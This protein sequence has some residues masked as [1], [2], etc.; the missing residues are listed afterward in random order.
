MAAGVGAGA[1]EAAALDDAAS[2]TGCFWRQGPMRGAVQSQLL[3]SL[4]LICEHYACACFSLRATRSFDAERLTVMACIAAVADAVL[5]VQVTDTPSLFCVHYSGR[6]GG[7][8][9]PFGFELGRYAIES[10]NLELPSPRLTLSRAKVLRYFLALKKVVPDGNVILRMEDRMRMCTGDAAL[11]GQLC[12]ASGFPRGPSTEALAGYMTGEYSALCRNFP[13]LPLCRDIVFFLKLLMVPTSEGL[14][15]LRAWVPS[16]ATLMWA[17]AK[18]K[19]GAAAAGPPT[20]EVKGFHRQLDCAELVRSARESEDRSAAGGGGGGGGAG[21]FGRVAQFFGIAKPRAPPSGAD[22]STLVGA[23]ISSEDDVLGVRVLPDFGGRLR[24]R[25]VELL[26]CYLTAPYLRI[27]LLL[28]FFSVAERVTALVTDELQAALDGALFEPGLWQ[29]A[30]NRPIPQLVPPPVVAPAVGAGGTSASGQRSAGAAAVAAS[31]AHLATPAGLL[32]NELIHCP[33]ATLGPLIALVQLVLEL[34]TGHHTAS[35]VPAALYL[36]RLAVRV[37]AYATVLL[38]TCAKGSAEAASAF[39]HAPTPPALQQLRAKTELLRVTLRASVAP[40]LGG[41]LARAFKDADQKTCCILHAHIAVIYGGSA[42]LDAPAANALV[43][44]QVFILSNHEIGLDVQSAPEGMDRS[45]RTARRHAVDGADGAENAD[46]SGAGSVGSSKD[47]GL[48]VPVTELMNLFQAK[49]VAVLKWL[50]AHP[51][52]C[53]QIMEGTVG[54]VGRANTAAA[55]ALSIKLE[56]RSWATLRGWGGAG[57]YVPEVESALLDTP[58]ALPG[59]NY[60]AWL[61]RASERNV[62]TEINVQLGQ[63]T[64]QRHH[65]SPLPAY[66]RG[67]PHLHDAMGSLPTDEVIQCIEVATSARSRLVRLPGLRHDVKYFAPALAPPANPFAGGH[68]RLYPRALKASEAWVHAAFERAREAVAPPNAPVWLPATELTSAPFVVLTIELPVGDDARAGSGGVRTALREVV[69]IRSTRVVNAFDVVSHGRRWY[70]QLVWSSSVQWCLADLGPAAPRRAPPP[71][72]PAASLVIVRELSEATGAQEYV[73]PELLKGVLPDALLSRYTFWRSVVGGDLLGYP[74]RARKG[75]PRIGMDGTPKRAGGQES[76]SKPN[77]EDTATANA[78]IAAAA[79]AAMAE[80]EAEADDDPHVLRISLA[81]EP[82]TGGGVSAAGAGATSRANAAA[83][84]V[85]AAMGEGAMALVQRVPVKGGTEVLRAEPDPSR[86]TLTLL[87][88]LT[89]PS[90]TPA[91]ALALA[92]APLEALSH[93]LMWT[94]APV[95]SSADRCRAEM[96]ELPRLRLRFRAKA[97]SGNDEGAPQRVRL[98]SDE[99]TGM[100]ISS[101]AASSQ[102][103]CPRTAALLAGLPHVLLEHA[104]GRLAA[105]VSGAMVPV[106]RAPTAPAHV[107]LCAFVPGGSAWVANL[108]PTSSS[109]L[110]AVHPSKTMLSSPSAAAGL[111]LLSIRLLRGEYTRAV[112]VVRE[113]GDDS[114]F[115]P[116]ARQLF[117]RLGGLLRPTALCAPDLRAVR[118]RLGMWLD[119][120]A[121]GVRF[122]WPSAADLEPYVIQH[123]VVSAA[124]R[125]SPHEEQ[126]LLEA[127][128]AERDGAKPAEMENRLA[129]LRALTAGATAAHASKSFSIRVRPPPMPEHGAT[130]ASAFDLL[131][132]RTCMLT[133]KGSWA[134]SWGTLSY[135][136]PEGEFIEGTPALIAMKGWLRNG[137][138]IGGGRDGLGFLFLYELMTGSLN[139]RVLPTDT[140][141]QWGA[142]LL[143][144]LPAETTQKDGML[145]SILRVLA[146]NP[147]LAAAMP[148]FE[149]TRKFKISTIFRGQDI[150]KDLLQ[151]V[152]EFLGS[153]Q[154]QLHWPSV[155]ALYRSADSVRVSSATL[156]VVDRLAGARTTATVGGAAAAVAIMDEPLSL[157]PAERLWLAP[158]SF[159]AEREA[160]GAMPLI[161]F[162]AVLAGANANPLLQVSDADAKAFASLPL[163]PVGLASY[164]GRRPARLAGSTPSRLPFDLSGVP[165]ARTNVGRATLKRLGDDLADYARTRDAGGGLEMLH[166]LEDQLAA[167][168][169]AADSTPLQRAL[170]HIEGLRKALRALAEKDRRFVEAA[171]LALPSLAGALPSSFVSGDG[172]DAEAHALLRTAGAEPD[173]SFGALLK[174]TLSARGA[175]LLLDLNPFLSRPAADDVLQLTLCTAAATVRVTQAGRADALARELLGMLRGLEIAK[176]GS[177]NADAV[178]SAVHATALKARALASV[179]GEKRHYAAPPAGAPPPSANGT[180]PAKVL[181]ARLLSFEFAQSVMLREVQVSLLNSFVADA[182]RGTSVCQQLLMGQGKTTVIGPALALL[183]ATSERLVVMT[184]PSHLVGF[185]RQ[186]LRERLAGVLSRPVYVLTCERASLVTQHMLDCLRATRERCGVVVCDA[187]SLKSLLLKTVECLHLLDEAAFGSPPSAAAAAAAARASKLLRFKSLQKLLGLRRRKPLA[188]TQ[189]VQTA[190]QQVE[191]CVAML[192]VVHSGVLI[193]DEVDSLLTPLK[194]ELNWPLGERL[195]L[196]HTPARWELA[197]HLIDGLLHVET[198]R[199][200]VDFA[201]SSEA[202]ALLQ[203]LDST[204]RAGADQRVVQLRPH[205]IVLDDGFYANQLRPLLARWAVL[206]LRSQQIRGLTDE[207]VLSY[208]LGGPANAP[209]AAKVVREQ[210]SESHAKSVNLARTC[211]DSVLPHI[212]SRVNLVHY[213]LLPPEMAAAQ[214]TPAGVFSSANS[215]SRLLLAIPYLGKGMPSTA[216]EF[217]NPD[218]LIGLTVLAYRFQGL[219]RTDV[220]GV[221]LNLLEMMAE[222][223]GPYKARPACRT[224]AHWVELGG[225]LVRGAT[226]TVVPKGGQAAAPPPDLMA[227]DRNGGTPGRPEVPPLQLIDVRDHELIDVLDTLLR[228]LP[229]VI[230][231]YLHDFAFPVT[232]ARQQTKLSANGQDLGGSILAPLRVGFSGTPNDLLP[233]ELGKCQ[234][235]KGD[236]GRV[237]HV[238][239]SELI[240][241]VEAI[242]PG[243]NVDSVLTWVAKRRPALHALID[244]GAIITGYSNAEVA[245]QL[246]AM[247][248]PLAAVVFLDANGEKLVLTRR[249]AKPV[250][251]AQ[252]GVPPAQRFTYYDQVN[253]TGTDI[254]QTADARAAIT[255]GHAMTFRDL[256]QGAF[257][258]RGIGTGQTV[259]ILVQPEVVKLVASTKGRGIGLMSSSGVSPLPSLADVC[260]W[261]VVCSIRYEAMQFQLLCDQRLANVWRKRAFRV[262]RERRAQLKTPA[263]EA[264]GIRANAAQ[265]KELRGSSQGGSETRAALQV[266]REALDFHVEASVPVARSFSDVLREK[267]DIHRHLLAEPAEMSVVQSI[268][269]DMRQADSDS[270]AASTTGVMAAASEASGMQLEAEAVAEAEAEAEAEQEQEQQQEQQQQVQQQKEEEMEPD[271]PQKLPFARDDEALKPWRL[272]LLAVPVGGSAKPPIPP[273]YKTADFAVHR[274]IVAK[275]AH[276]HFPDYLLQTTNWFQPAWRKNHRRVKNVIMMLEI[277]QPD[278]MGGNS[279][280]GASVG[281]VQRSLGGSTQGGGSAPTMVLSASQETHLRSVFSLFDSRG[282]GRLT[283]QDLVDALKAIDVDIPPELRGPDMSAISPA[284]SGLGNSGNGAGMGDLSMLGGGGAMQLSNATG[285]DFEYSDFKRHTCAQLAAVALGAPGRYFVICS[286]VE[287]EALRGVMHIAQTSYNGLGLGGT[288]LALL[289]HGSPLDVSPGCEPA[290]D[291]QAH[292]ARQCARFVDSEAEYDERDAIAL[293][294]ALRATP[295]AARKTWF[296]DVRACKRRQQQL[297]QY[298]TGSDEGGKGRGLL[299]RRRK[300][301]QRTRHGVPA[302]LESLFQA[303]DEFQLLE[304]SAVLRRVRTLLVRRGLSARDAFALFNKSRSGTITCRE[305][306]SGLC[307]LQVNLSVAQLHSTVRALDTT[308]DG[309][310]GADD[311]RAAF[312]ARVDDDE[313][314]GSASRAARVEEEPQLL[315]LLSSEQPVGSGGVVQAY[316]SSADGAGNGGMDIAALFAHSGSPQGMGLAALAGGLEEA[317][318][319]IRDVDVPELGPLGSGRDHGAAGAATNVTS[320]DLRGFEV[321]VRKAKDFE[322]VW[323]AGAQGWADASASVWSPAA[324]STGLGKASV[325]LCVGHY[326]SREGNPAR[327]K[328]V[329][330]RLIVELA[331][332]S[333]SFGLAGLGATERFLEV[334]RAVLPHP[335]RFKLVWSTLAGG[336]PLYVWRPIAPSAAYVALGFVATCSEDEPLPSSVHCVPARWCVE[337]RTP[338]RA[339]GE[340]TGSGANSRPGSLWVVNAAGLLGATAGHT[341]PTDAA[342]DLREDIFR[343]EHHKLDKMI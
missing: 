251:L 272:D 269:A 276:L 100:F 295:P 265:A 252:C 11:L 314:A 58:S 90:G 147:Q 51:K 163:A 106:P 289:A 228:G 191:L 101:D 280:N 96:V 67:H 113:C 229:E 128:M 133:E 214:Q 47:G 175:E 162:R 81:G 104:D 120:S 65:L 152:R 63:L 208:L 303:A 322:Q 179:L 88:T 184:M 324:D 206:W 115:G 277:Q 160:G 75:R 53:G 308:G 317:Q 182:Q 273:F 282:R 50:H 329:A 137:L 187:S 35:H 165:L 248:L 189:D 231:H 143:R 302:A 281:W 80:A 59:E 230:G 145:M 267:A 204:L 258:M 99:H 285:G 79:I 335:R 55:S 18:V 154:G 211:L 27:P 288:K 62:R 309:E 215:R 239:T 294:R 23:L 223:E 30:T 268:L 185:S 278:G 1:A 310:L 105:L 156:L 6:A 52:E 233:L 305:L 198:G 108:G 332:T 7:P 95:G 264:A 201:D 155:P 69:V 70:R 313:E 250:P 296:V 123:S 249:S 323:T 87:H 170:K 190:V 244:T 126:R 343:L 132:D 68:G 141:F 116:D 311:F 320:V 297:A 130:V 167:Y 74:R 56:V 135:T 39:V 328:G 243:W 153:K 83:A 301:N 89:A 212:L 25:E 110:Y 140:P 33:E 161:S 17:T 72:A 197:W 85:A 10:E 82:G 14:P 124:C 321:R 150:V 253:T 164:V 242:D 4:Q 293:L 181:D 256:A 260:A 266:F 319:Q 227:L 20:Y 48:G 37:E 78:Q 144:M 226:P 44:A 200:A 232:M 45:A 136:R 188:A 38:D 257:R 73:P 219:R 326:P 92:L 114:P 142:A 221:V 34:D 225:G 54:N 263:L 271:D 117:D 66:I 112:E 245:R 43:T 316:G 286:L 42:E 98:Y 235:A 21:M 119:G 111:H 254:E 342:Y 209:A 333:S 275:A 26:L 149:D 19:G 176:R 148:K 183:L 97:G 61:R 341:R 121:A 91:G 127:Y 122:P 262:V 327:A 199:I 284:W 8:T 41:W 337:T 203:Q 93:V 5:R 202:R 57:R 338:A 300:R 3:R 218:V 274:S 138:E 287:A 180:G 234:Y 298:A 237:L 246:L 159:A 102:R 16:D 306:A 129:L 103:R 270:V 71:Q 216:S 312:A 146:N 247:G 173:P 336:K 139:L 291:Y 339:V 22:P 131:A 205:L 29:E 60:E 186:L 207:Q 125:L 46:G 331:S 169:A 31:R 24:P 151:Q 279:G 174:L 255:L 334:A 261:L 192:E 196:D 195:P 94:A 292:V 15:D 84:T 217:A 325:R 330:A 290:F 76:L 166:L 304:Q 2:A 134:S 210:L 158:S 36:T 236:D 12:L 118:L 9:F 171:V 49:R 238:L 13:E 177:A 178:T 241:S 109:F 64:L 307:W 86:P 240:A 172:A 340:A 40:M 194:S 220:M 259:I 318:K 168:A 283:R 107:P 157:A 222:Q 299:V 193:L 32:F 28:R 213:G 315:D 77:A 224:F